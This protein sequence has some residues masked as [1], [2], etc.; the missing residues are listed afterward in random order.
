M[1]FVSGLDFTSI[2]GLGLDLGLKLGLGLR[3]RFGVPD[4]DPDP[5]SIHGSECRDWM[6]RQMS[7]QMYSD[8]CHDRRSRAYA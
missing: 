5:S 2:P 1:G 7:R 3:G 8:G 4:P 6:S